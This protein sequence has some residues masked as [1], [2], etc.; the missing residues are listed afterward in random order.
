MAHTGP[1]TN[2]TPLNYHIGMM[3]KLFVNEGGVWV[4]HGELVTPAI[5]ADLG[6]FTGGLNSAY[7]AQYGNAPFPSD[8]DSAGGGTI[9]TP[10]LK[11]AIGWSD[12][13]PIKTTSFVCET[14]MAIQFVVPGNATHQA[15]AG[16][17]VL[18]EYN[19]PITARQMTLST[20]AGDFRALDPTGVNGPFA[21]SNGTIVTVAFNIGVTPSSG[22]IGDVPPAPLVAGQAYYVNI[23]NFSIDVGGPACYPGQSTNV[24][25]QFN[26][27]HS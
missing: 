15:V 25:V 1:R 21:V 11:T 4:Y 27:P 24:Q 8:P 17:A 19:G 26:W 23:R 16:F 6:D 13:A 10:T 20:T 3:N 9:I 22:Q 18:S 14:V 5:A 2:A 12:I 7:H